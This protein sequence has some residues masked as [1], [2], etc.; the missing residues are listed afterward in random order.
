M[1][2]AAVGEL[3]RIGGRKR[4]SHSETKL[5]VQSMR[6]KSVLARR[7]F[8]EGVGSLIGQWLCREENCR[9]GIMEPS[10]KHPFVQ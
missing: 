3:T 10:F 8:Q 4:D 5:R 2:C 6:E 7:S 1:S 9:V